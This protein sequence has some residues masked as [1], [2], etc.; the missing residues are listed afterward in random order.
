MAISGRPAGEL[1]ALLQKTRA[2]EMPELR[3]SVPGEEFDVMRS[4][5]AEWLCSLPEVR[6]RVFDRAKD[7]R[8][9][10]YDGE[11]GTWRGAAS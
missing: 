7:A 10:V 2:C 8:L 9:I 1:S 4:E 3:H 6:Q 11:S 5:V